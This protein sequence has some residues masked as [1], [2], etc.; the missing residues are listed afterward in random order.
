LLRRALQGRTCQLSPSSCR[1]SLSPPLPDRRRTGTALALLQAFLQVFA[2]QTAPTR[3]SQFAASRLPRRRQAAAGL[4]A[5]SAPDQ[6]CLRAVE[7]AITSP[8]SGPLALRQAAA[9]GAGP[10]RASRRPKC[11][12]GWRRLRHAAV[13]A[14]GLRRARARSAWRPFQLP[15]VP[16]MTGASV[17]EAPVAVRQARLPRLRRNGSPA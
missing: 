6:R 4:P 13:S 5:L 9:G 15:L 1:S 2:A 12:S 11:R 8:A 16:V 10:E 14:R 3:R 7:R 17:G